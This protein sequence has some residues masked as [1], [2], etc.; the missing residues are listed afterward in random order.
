MV[1]LYLFDDDDD[2]LEVIS[3]LVIEEIQGCNVV[4]QSKNN[5]ELEACMIRR[6]LSVKSELPEYCK[7]LE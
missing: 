1:I 2:H 6:V 5:K 7:M 3:N 4:L